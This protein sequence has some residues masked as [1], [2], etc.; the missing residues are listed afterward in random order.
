MNPKTNKFEPMFDPCKEPQ[1]PIAV[2]LEG[3][4]KGL[5]FI[6]DPNQLYRADGTR[7]PKTW[8]IFTVG[9]EIVVK[10]Y[11]FTVAYIGESALLLE[12][13]GPILI[14]EKKE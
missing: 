11:R 10:N 12:P 9:E 6:E 3:L 5:P 2:T 14:G 1:G 8:S 13:A 7:V 4:D